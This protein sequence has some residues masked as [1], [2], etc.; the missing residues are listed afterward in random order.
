MRHTSCATV[1]VVVPLYNKGK[2][3]ERAITSILEQTFPASEIIVV[4]D[5]STDD[6]PDKVKEL[7]QSHPKIMLISQQNRG[8]G[9]ARNAG[10]AIAHGKYVSFLDA[11]DEWH[12]AFLETGLSLL[13]DQSANITVVWTGYQIS[14]DGGKR[15]CGTNGLGGIYEIC[16]QTDISVVNN[17]MSYIWTCSAIMR[18][19]VA[20]KWGGFFDQYKCLLGEDKYLFIK[21]LFNERFG[22]IKEPLAIYHK[23]ASDLWG[24]G[25]INMLTLEPFLEEPDDIINACPSTTRHIL[26]EHLLFWALNK[27]EMYA[28]IGQKKQATELLDRFISK[29][30][31]YTKEAARVQLFARISPILPLARRIWRFSK[32]IGRQFGIMHEHFK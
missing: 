31:P 10:L 12:P 6:G 22:I 18:T 16:P 15:T 20:I 8:P 7:A 13:E 30:Y 14:P 21:L 5:G 2:Y 19:Q 27:A 9:A 26:R 24:G 3:V 25:N 29:D 11:D 1:S 4:D 17:I 28:K 32:S 23:E